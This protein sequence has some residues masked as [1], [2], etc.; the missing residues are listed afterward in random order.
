ML[1]TT[2]RGLVIEIVWV[3]SYQSRELLEWGAN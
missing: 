1:A 2:S 3:E